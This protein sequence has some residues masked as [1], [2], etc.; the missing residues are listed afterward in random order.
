[1]GCKGPTGCNPS[2]LRCS[3]DCQLV[4]GRCL[5][6]MSLGRAGASSGRARLGQSRASRRAGTCR[7]VCCRCS[8]LPCQCQ[9]GRRPAVAY[10][11][12]APVF[13]CM[14][15]HVLCSRMSAALCKS[16][17]AS[18]R[19]PEFL[20]IPTQVGLA[21][22]YPGSNMKQAGGSHAG[23]GKLLPPLLACWWGAVQQLEQPHPARAGAVYLQP[24]FTAGAL[25]R[26]VHS[27]QPSPG[28]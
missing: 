16:Y 26:P 18:T 6:N 21:A 5:G 8:S 2:H 24:G 25:R 28:S 14:Y 15:T 22:M 20:R 23:R 9:L 13:V 10:G 27:A 19:A 17:A 11:S 3:A 7:W 1:M 12:L 4:H